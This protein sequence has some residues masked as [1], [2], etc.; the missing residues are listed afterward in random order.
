MDQ[1]KPKLPELLAPAGNPERLRTALH[2]GADAVYVGLKA[3]SLRNYADNFTPAELKEACALAHSMGRRVY[4][5]LNAFARDEDLQALPQLLEQAAEAEADALIVNDPGVIRMAK[6][7]TPH[8]PLHLSTQ[9]N[10]L[11]AQAAAFWWEQG[12]KR[13]VLARELSIE[14]MGE[15]IR[16]S[17]KGLEFEAFVHGAMC[18]A[19]SGRCLLS[20]YLAGRDPNRGECAQPCRWSYALRERGPGAAYGWFPVEQDQRGT[21]VLNSR[22]LRLIQYI[23]QLAEAG[24]SSLKIEG[25]MKSIAYVATVVNAYRMA[26]DAYGQSLATGTPYQ[27][28]PDLLQELE[29]ASHRPYTT[30]FALGLGATP[31]QAPESAA[32]IGE[33]TIGAVVLSYD[34]RQ[35]RAAIEQRNKFALGDTLSILSPGT[36]AAPFGW[37]ACGIL[38]APPGRIPPIPGSGCCWPAILPCRQGISCASCQRHSPGP[39]PK[40]W[41]HSAACGPI[42]RN[43]RQLRPHLSSP[44]AGRPWRGNA[45]STPPSRCWNKWGRTRRMGP[46]KAEC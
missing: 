31:Y 46:G 36:W 34:P 30:G 17:P 32:Y 29:R 41:T 5:T 22:D 23:P 18:V 37:R 4:V 28:D 44:F 27:L 24:L 16:Q 35:G 11:N 45:L 13:I 39:L 43:H 9:A 40:P 38:T 25:R 19:Y 26:L 7:M 8:M 33:G 10:T 2:Y 14:Q 42:A 6:E 20:A 21:Y 15:L 3:M 1:P 12:V